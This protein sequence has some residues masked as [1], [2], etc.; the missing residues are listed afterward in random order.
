MPNSCPHGHCPFEELGSLGHGLLKTYED[1]YQMSSICMISENVITTVQPTRCTMP[2]VG[3]I[4]WQTSQ[5]SNMSAFR[6]L[7]QASGNYTHI[8]QL[9]LQ[10]P[11]FQVCIHLILEKKTAAWGCR[12]SMDFLMDVLPPFRSPFA[13]RSPC[14]SRSLLLRPARP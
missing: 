8:C 7:Y 1:L 9:R 2:I 14:T 5:P 12:I 10:L 11:S 3:D 6:P 4:V 13:P